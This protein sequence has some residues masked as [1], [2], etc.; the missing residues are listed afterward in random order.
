MYNW[1]VRPIAGGCLGDPAQPIGSDNRIV[2]SSQPT[3]L[4][5]RASGSGIGLVML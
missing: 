3:G 5:G 2:H 1:K 4:G